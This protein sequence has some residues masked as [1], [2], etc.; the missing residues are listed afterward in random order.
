M[1]E[2][3]LEVI[4]R[5]KQLYYLHHASNA[6]K[7]DKHR[8]TVSSRA[9]ED[10]FGFF[11]WWHVTASGEIFYTEQ[12]LGLFVRSM[13]PTMDGEAIVASNLTSE[14]QARFA[15]LSFRRSL[16]QFQIDTIFKNF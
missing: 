6:M 5:R 1:K 16:L 9:A 15:Y 10:R 14:M 13:S 11:A 12:P 4:A 7:E 8:R 2:D 3:K